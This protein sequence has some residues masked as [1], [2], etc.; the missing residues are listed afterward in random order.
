MLRQNYKAFSGMPQLIMQYSKYNILSKIK[1][2][3][4]SFIVNLLTGNADILSPSDAGVLIDLK[5]NGFKESHLSNELMSK[6][7]FIDSA[8][9]KKNYRRAY[10]DFV[11][12]RDN[13]E[14]QIFFVANYSCNFSCT[15]CYQDEY[16]PEKS[17]LNTET[18]D[19]FFNY[20]IKEFAGRKKY[21][22][23]FGGE[24]LLNSNKQRSIISYLIKKSNELGLELSY[25][26]NGYYLEEY[27][28]L[29]KSGQTREI[30]VTLD[31][32]ELVHD[33][34]RLL[35]NGAGTFAKIVKGIDESIKNKI[36]VNLRMVV[37]KENIGNLPE[38]AQLAIDKGWTESPYF[39]TQIGRNYE[40]HHCQT[41]S[42]NLFTRASLYE[43]LYR[44]TK[45]YPYILEF[46]KP[47]YSISKFLWENQELPKPL[48]D[49]CPACKTEWA[50]D[51]TGNI[52]SC[53]AT[54]GKADES[55]GT[56]YPEVRLNTEK[57]E[58]WQSRDVTE[59]D[60]CKSCNLQLACG[61]GCGSVAKNNNGKV[62]STD[63]N[64]VTELLELGFSAYFENVKN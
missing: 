50:F 28:D 57:I 59:I 16:T 41:T 1:D 5:E 27:I 11:D 8:E 64:P 63:C 35:K 17:E 47:A 3:E 45:E 32:T 31:G 56:F 53:T 33:K 51:Y 34:R 61:G 37:D 38:I 44:L 55:L 29:I 60:E 25:V 6:G 14:I 52:Y 40:L 62:C 39:K 7:Y 4:N 36:T 54:V 15:Y 12:D 18:I 30:Q 26:T 13:D 58:E 42:S 46:Y 10:L 43:E 19:A 9:E 23:V 22:T 20:I 24:P 2:S 21:I 48:F 49:S